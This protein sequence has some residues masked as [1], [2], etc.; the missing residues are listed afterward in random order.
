MTLDEGESTGR[1]L[2][3]SALAGGAQALGQPV[4]AIAPGSRAD[5]VTLDAEHPALAAAGP[6]SWLDC[7]IFSAGRALVKDVVAGGIKVVSDGRHRR[8]E[9]IAARYRASLARLVG[10]V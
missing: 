6:E 8:R 7:W 5:L 4:A 1:R 9:E 3:A 2:F 10:D